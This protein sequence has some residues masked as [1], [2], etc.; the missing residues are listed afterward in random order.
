MITKPLLVHTQSV[1]AD[2]LRLI[3]SRMTDLYTAFGLQSALTHTQAGAILPAES[4]S[5]VVAGWNKSSRAVAEAL[6]VQLSQSR[7]L[8]RKWY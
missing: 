2:F 4:A 6:R 3:Q 8:E 5:A 7:L 1:L